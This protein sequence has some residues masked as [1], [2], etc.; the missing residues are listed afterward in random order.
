MSL[1]SKR[2]LNLARSQFTCEES[3]KLFASTEVCIKF[4]F[5]CGEG[6]VVLPHSDTPLELLT[7][8]LTATGKIASE[9]RSN[10]VPIIQVLCFVI[11]ELTL[12]TNWPTLSLVSIRSV[13]MG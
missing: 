7:H 1:T 11:S 8:I 10:I 5:C 6:K 4:S 2:F 13:Y 3:E 12:I 9:F